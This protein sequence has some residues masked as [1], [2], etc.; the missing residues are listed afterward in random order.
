MTN[1]NASSKDS[2]IIPNLKESKAL[3][4]FVITFRDRDHMYR[5][6]KWLN[7]NVGKGS[8]KWTSE[9][10]ILKS[11]KAGKPVARKI[12]IYVEDF[13]EASALYLNLI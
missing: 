7:D 10:R 12:Y 6:V 11:I 4:T 5:V 1:P 3:H 2:K 9:G 13:D 8:D